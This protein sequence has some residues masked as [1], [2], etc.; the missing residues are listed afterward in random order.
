MAELETRSHAQLILLFGIA[1]LSLIGAY[2]LFVTAREGGVWATTNQGRFIQPSMTVD[3]VALTD[4]QGRRFATNALWWVWVVEPGAC[5]QQCQRALKQIRQLHV[6]LNKDAVRI[7]RAFLTSAD[8]LPASEQL[9]EQFPQLVRLTGS[10]NR[11][12]RG[13]YI[14]DPIGNLVLWYPLD[15]AGSP[16]LDDMKR[17]LKVS[18]IG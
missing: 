2:V 9:L 18:Q 13:V 12:S 15:E 3:E 7:R 11:L 16:V 6:L 14:V 4:G 1:A 10:V 17:L 5:R 8:R